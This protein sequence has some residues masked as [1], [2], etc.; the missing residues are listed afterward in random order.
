MDHPAIVVEPRHARRQ[1]I[2]TRPSPIALMK[3]DDAEIYFLNVFALPVLHGLDSVAAVAAA[4]ASPP[5]SSSPIFDAGDGY[6]A[7]L[8]AEMSNEFTPDA[9]TSSS[10]TSAD[11]QRR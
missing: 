5:I 11:S 6:A 4:Y 1:G 2:E 7:L 9:S 10:R 8:S 3:Y